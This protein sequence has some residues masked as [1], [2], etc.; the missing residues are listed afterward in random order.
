MSLL[1]LRPK[2]P[3]NSPTTELNYWDGN[4]HA[5][6]KNE[7]YKQVDDTG[8][9]DG[10]STY[11]YPGII[12]TW[13]KDLYEIENHTTENDVINSVAVC[14]R[15]ST[16]GGSSGKVVL[17]T[18]STN[19]ET[20]INVTLYYLFK[21]TY[22]TNP[23]TISAWTWAEVDAIQ[24]GL[25]LYLGVGKGAAANGT[26]VYIEVLYGLSLPTVTTQNASDIKKSVLANLQV[27]A[28]LDDAAAWLV[29]GVTQSFEVVYSWLIAGCYATT[30][31]KA[32]SGMRFPGVWIPQGATITTAYLTVTCYQSFASA[33][34]KTRIRGEDVDDATAFSDF[35]DFDARVRTTACVD[36][37]D[38]P[39]WTVG[40]EY[41]TPD[42]KDVIQEIVDRGG[43]A[44][45]NAMVIFWDDFDDRTAHEPSKF[46]NWYAFD[47]DA[48]KAPILYIEWTYA[49]TWEAT[50]NGT[51]TNAGGGDILERGFDY[52]LT[53]EYG[54]EITEE[55]AWAAEAFAL[56]LGNLDASTTYHFKAKARN[57]LGWG[58]G[59]D[60]SFATGEAVEGMGAL[61]R[62]IN[63]LGLNL[64]GVGRNN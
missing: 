38:I 45:G 50:L 57:A 52:G 60:K 40:V 20:D 7:N 19:Y 12:E 5:P 33:E 25:N 32:G 47:G 29:D 55:D 51:V 2:A 39:T 16:A 58:Y 34:V 43:W 23:N 46:R 56:I 22:T 3:E 53:D 41:T 30:G 49:D 8:E 28:S 26:Q 9:G 10:A 24:A 54:S 13:L 61:Y 6:D 17:R 63:P 14:V 1:I 48:A 27:K 4:G 62:R 11:V 64:Y 36:H 15:V 21:K 35:A 59:D 18:H 42:F 31:H 37:D 44:P